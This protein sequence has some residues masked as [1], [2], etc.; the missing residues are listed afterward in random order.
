MTGSL[1]GVSL[2]FWFSLRWTLPA[3]RPVCDVMFILCLFSDGE[4]CTGPV[5][6]GIDTG[7]TAHSPHW[8]HVAYWELRDRVG[9]LRPV[10]EP[11]INIFQNLPHGDGLC[12]QVLQGRSEFDSVRRTREKIGFGIVLSS[13]GDGVWVYNRA[14]HP[15]F[16]NSPTLEDP[17]SRTL[18]VHKVC[19]GYSLKIFDYSLAHLLL[20]VSDPKYLDG[21]YDPKTIRISF[22]K[23]WG[24]HY[25]RQFITSCPCWLEVM[26]SF[27]SSRR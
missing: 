21:P 19:P 24:S 10:H 26:L 8:C 1:S 14:Q 3:V 15:I 27:D 25:S 9:R 23:G 7:Q 12:L 6:N 11:H 2:Y 17:H 22:A 18:Y 20:D 4:I 13:E 5:S 16:V